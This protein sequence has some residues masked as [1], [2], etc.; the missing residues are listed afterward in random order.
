MRKNIHKRGALFIEYAL[1]LAFVIVVGVVFTSNNGIS[2]SIA[3]IFGN[4]STTLAEATKDKK[5][6]DEKNMDFTKELIAYIT[7]E[8]GSAD[9]AITPYNTTGTFT[10]KNATDGGGYDVHKYFPQ[11]WATEMGEDKYE[12]M[13]GNISY[14]FFPDKGLKTGNSTWH[15]YIYN[16]ENNGNML[17]KECN[18]GEKISTEVYTYNVNT[19]KIVKQES[20][21]HTVDISNGYKVIRA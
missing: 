17:L 15:V 20:E 21:E 2:S 18:K 6:V 3:H 9:S 16:P 12:A 7:G 14:A 11:R 1:I 8:I 4:A 10:F 19:K 13:V 5:T